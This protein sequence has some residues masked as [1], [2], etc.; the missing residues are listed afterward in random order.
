M[1]KKTHVTAVVTTAVGV[2]LAGFVMYQVRDVA[3]IGDAQRGYT[4]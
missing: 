2:L 3:G 4:G 1:P